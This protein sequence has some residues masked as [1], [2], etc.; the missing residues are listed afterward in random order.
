MDTFGQR[1]ALR[2]KELGLTQ[3]ELAD[4]L[5]TD[6][7]L[8]GRYERDKVRPSIDAVVRLAQE[9]D[10]TVSYLL[11]E[12]DQAELLKD[13]TMLKRMQ[14]IEQLP[15]EQR[16]HVLYALDAMLRDAQAYQT[17]SA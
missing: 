13:P 3:S 2:R 5:D 16:K 9:I 11:G 1:L 7:S 8:I 17:Y 14:S 4:Q 15:D 10:T 12:I 6:P